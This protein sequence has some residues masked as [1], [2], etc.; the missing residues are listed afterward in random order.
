MMFQST[1]RKNKGKRSFRTTIWMLAILFLLAAGSILT[2]SFKFAVWQYQKWEA[3]QRRLVQA[4]K[5]IAE[6]PGM[7]QENRDLLSR[8]Y[9]R[10][11]GYDQEVS[12]SKLLELLLDAAHKS[13]ISFVSIRPF[14]LKDLG[15]Y[16]QLD[17]KLEIRAGYHQLGSFFST[18][19]KGNS[20]VRF[21]S[22]NMTGD[23]SSAPSILAVLNGQAMFVKSNIDEKDLDT[24]LAHNKPAKGKGDTTFTYSAKYR[25][26]FLPSGSTE[27]MVAQKTGPVYRLKG[28]VWDAK[29]PLAVVM[30]ESGVT[31]FMRAGEKMGND[32]LLSVKQNMVIFKRKNGTKYEIN[33]NE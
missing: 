25:D 3:S 27:A 2:P 1:Y 14:P 33:I 10:L 28:V 22:L 6:L 23:K 17:F 7:E 24:L 18:L 13:Q 5:L 8:N 15:K 21:K 9:F 31:Y 26:P 32:L 4:K 12:Q 29:N 19:E 30:D 16:Y 11:A 20:L